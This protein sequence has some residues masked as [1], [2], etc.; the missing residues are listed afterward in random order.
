MLGYCWFWK[1]LEALLQQT[2]GETLLECPVNILA[3]WVFKGCK[4]CGD[5]VP[6]GSRGGALYLADVH[7]SP[8]SNRDSGWW[9]CK[10]WMLLAC[11]IFRLV[12]V[13]PCLSGGTLDSSRSGITHFLTIHPQLTWL[14]HETWLFSM[15]FIGRALHNLFIYWFL[16]WSGSGFFITYLC[17]SIAFMWLSKC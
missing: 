15:C 1:Q 16:S 7:D 3:F 2:R 9:S 12:V 4:T 17:S 14:T 8:Y 10:D 5:E 13:F 11:T 6:L